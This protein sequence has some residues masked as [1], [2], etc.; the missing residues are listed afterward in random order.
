MDAWINVGL[1]ASAVGNTDSNSADSI[2]VPDGTVRVAG[3]KGQG[4][5]EAIGPS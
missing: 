5:P 2:S 3:P 1:P 4:S